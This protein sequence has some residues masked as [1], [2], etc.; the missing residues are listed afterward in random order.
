MD[1]TL[2]KGVQLLELLVQAESPRGVA[3]LARAAGWQ[4]SNVHRTLQT[5]AQ[6]GF[7]AQDADSGAYRCTLRLFEWGCRVVDRL[8]L[9]RL[10]RPHLAAL[11]QRTQETIHLS[12]L[13]GADIVYLD[14]IDSAQP[15]RAYS[16]IGGRAPA[17]CVATGK[18]LLA[19]APAGALDRLPSPL[20]RPTIHSAADR[21]ALRLQFQRIRD[22][23]FA[24]NREEWRL[25]VRGLGAA[26]FDPHGQAIAAVGL[27]AP[28][29]RL[30]AAREKEFGQLVAA[31]AQSIGAELGGGTPAVDVAASGPRRA[32]QAACL[33]VSSRFV[34]NP[35]KVNPP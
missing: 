34:S 35:S 5:W 10:A 3:D 11:A 26:V 7:V 30:P 28:A 23:G 32:A 24:T 31:A 14:K 13:E 4:P 21:A 6:L 33:P 12:M 8:D 19:H 1:K 22:A 2:V 15:V 17:H 29:A 18:A 20:P 27:S 9:R 25:G 16:E